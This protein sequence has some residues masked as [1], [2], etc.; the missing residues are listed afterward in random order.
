VGQAGL[1]STCPRVGG[2][3]RLTEQPCGAH[4]FRTVQH[5]ERVAA[6]TVDLG[7]DR[8]VRQPPHDERRIGHHGGITCGPSEVGGGAAGRPGVA[9]RTGAELT[10]GKVEQK[11]STLRRGGV[12]TPAIIVSGGPPAPVA[13]WAIAGWELTW[14][15]LGVAAWV[16]AGRAASRR[17]E[18]RAAR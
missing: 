3:G 12:L 10:V 9:D 16:A 4:R 17:A 18:S 8:V 11:P 5:R 13:L 2:E 7:A 1:G 6:E 14:L 15:L